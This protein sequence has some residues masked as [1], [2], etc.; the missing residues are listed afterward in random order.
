MHVCTSFIA[1][2]YVCTS[3]IAA[4]HVHTSFIAAMYVHKALLPSA[5]GE[6]AIWGSPPPLEFENNDVI[7][8]FRANNH[9]IFAHAFG[10]R[11]KYR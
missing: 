6:G 10:A 2:M 11:I 1:A 5:P 7:C 8:C 3:F 4:M 9:Q